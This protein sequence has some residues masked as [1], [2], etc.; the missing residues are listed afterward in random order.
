MKKVFFFA[1]LYLS[2]VLH[3]GGMDLT[4]LGGLGNVSFD[5][6]STGLSGSGEFEGALYPFARLRL[7]EAV[8]DFLEFNAVMERDPILRNRFSAKARISSG[9]FAISAGP[10]LGLFN[11]SE[12]IVRPG[13]EAGIHF[14]IP[15]I[16]FA[17][18]DAGSTFGSLRSE[19][20]YEARHSRLEF[21][22]WLPNII[23]TISISEKSYDS[24]E[25]GNL[26]VR[27]RVLR[28][29][30]SAD[31]YTKNVPYE[32]VLNFGYET[33]TRNVIDRA[34]STSEEDV[35][36][37]IFLGAETSFNVKPELKLIFGGEIPV[38]SWGKKPLTK[39][40]KLVLFEVYAG[41]TYTIER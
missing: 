41:F 33:L 18:F 12:S 19:G 21:G 30:Y 24:W 10:L 5:T 23:N 38:Y 31:I 13:V 40:D 8:S 16:V 26:D 4:V 9:F 22:F 7:D 39:K 1:A 11:S 37:I 3:V 25:T 36:N 28:Y 17:A 14:D 20:D 15:G 34:A 2:A 27:D 32:I 35:Y 6:K 29:Q